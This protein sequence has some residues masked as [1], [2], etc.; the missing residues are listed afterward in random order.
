MVPVADGAERGQEQ[1]QTF[2]ARQER[3][4]AQVVPIRRQA[5]E[6]DPDDRDSGDRAGNIASARE[7]DARLEP[8][9]ARLAAL[10][11]RDDL[12]VDENASTGS[13]RSAPT[14]SG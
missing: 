5:V 3:E 1:P 10:V 6:E 14:S 4:A 9:E 12:A 11:G 8:L 7:A 2:L 13:A